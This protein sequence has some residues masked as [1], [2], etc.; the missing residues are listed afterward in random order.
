MALAVSLPLASMALAAPESPLEYQNPCP[1]KAPRDFPAGSVMEI[2]DREPPCRF[3]F[4]PTG[5]RLE[6]VVD[7]SRPDPGTVVL[8]DGL[9]RFYS[10]NAR[11]YDAVISVWNPEGEYL[12]SFGREGE[13]PGEF[14]V[15]GMLS[16]YLDGRNQLHVRDGGLSWSVFSADHEFLKRVVI[17]EPGMLAEERTTIILDNGAALAADDYRSDRSTYF[18][19]LRPDGTLDR[20]FGPV[21][22]KLAG[23]PGARLSRLISY[24]GGETFWAG[25]RFGDQDGY[26]VEEWGTDGELRRTLHRPASW[27]A[28]DEDLPMGPLQFHID[29]DD[30]L[31]Y[32]IFQRLTSEGIR[33]MKQ[34]IRDDQPFPRD[35]R[36]TETEAIIEMIDLRSGELL[37]SET[38]R[39]SDAMDFIPRDLF[40]GAMQGY[41][42]KEAEDGLPFVEIVAVELEAK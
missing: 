30:G 38:Y 29:E 40:R 20:S 17:T 9:G 35:K 8:M 41:A 32:M 28:W 42:Y 3:V 23:N 16:L 31:L 39:V 1:R 10:A 26:V 5:V 12:T 19:V 4:R 21:E 11:G 25:P 24:E 13:G 18:R 34:A 22:Q 15:R 33:L 7:G 14:T 27:Y 37:A 6:A 36:Y 2:K